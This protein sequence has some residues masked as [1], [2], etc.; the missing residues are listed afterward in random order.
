M[1]VR[2]A[3]LELLLTW[4]AP[5][6]Q[7]PWHGSRLLLPLSLDVPEGQAEK[8]WGI[9]SH[10]GPGLALRK[11][12]PDLLPLHP[13]AEV[14]WTVIISGHV[15][16]FLIALSQRVCFASRCSSTGAQQPLDGG[17]QLLG[18]AGVC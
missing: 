15:S 8:L 5:L 9:Q 2:S 4:D 12:P 3:L 6:N 1:G 10:R 7:N 11:P 16:S 13:P 17:N 18:T 14:S